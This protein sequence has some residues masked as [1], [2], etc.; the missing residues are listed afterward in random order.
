V[1]AGAFKVNDLMLET[2]PNRPVGEH[3]SNLAAMIAYEIAKSAGIPSYIYDSV[4]VDELDDIAR[5][6]GWPE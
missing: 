3:A 5:I 4:A 6:T 1:K 2:L